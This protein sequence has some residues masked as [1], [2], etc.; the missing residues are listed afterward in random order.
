MTRW[1]AAS[2]FEGRTRPPARRPPPARHGSGQR[3]SAAAALP[4]VA[5]RRRPVSPS[6]GP[7]APGCPSGRPARS[8]EPRAGGGRRCPEQRAAPCVRGSAARGGVRGQSSRGLKAGPPFRTG[9]QREL[10]RHVRAGGSGPPGAQQGKGRTTEV[11]SGMSGRYHLFSFSSRLSA[12]KPIKVYKLHLAVG[13]LY[14]AIFC[15]FSRLKGS[16]PRLVDVTWLDG[17]CWSCPPAT[18]L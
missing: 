15:K 10:V 5:G 17:C 18:G 9:R 3:P 1:K 7:R 11:C 14:F 12:W 16:S 13:S 2:G 8:C 4:A 6:R